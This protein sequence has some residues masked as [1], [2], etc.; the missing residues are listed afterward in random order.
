MD[1]NLIVTIIVALI[2]MVG[3]SM[4][5]IFG[6]RQFLLKRKDEKEER[7]VQKLIDDAIG[8]VRDELREEFNKGLQEREDTGKERFAINSKAIEENTR[9]IAEL[10][11]LVKDQVTKLEWFTE[12]MTALNNTVKITADSQRNASYDRI[13]SVSNIVLKNGKITITEKTNLRQLY[14]SWKELDGK[15]DKIDTLYEECMK[16]ELDMAE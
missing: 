15:D 7:N 10:T 16:L 5:T 9:A 14:S 13:L 4:G 11:L 12:S 2:G 8:K 1:K 3:A 6:Y